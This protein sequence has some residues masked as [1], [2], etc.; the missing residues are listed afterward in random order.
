MSDQVFRWPH[1]AIVADYWR[2]GTGFALSAIFLVLV[3][4]PAI[5]SVFFLALTAIFG[6]YLA[7]TILRS[8]TTL[9]LGPDGLTIS[10][11]LGTDTIR[12]DA[13]DQFALRYYT[14]RRDK[15]AG[16]MD[17]K[18]AG[19]G[20]KVALDDRFDGFRPILERAWEA[21]RTRDLGISSSTYANLT[22]AG[23]LPKSPSRSR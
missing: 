14:L 16:W 6:L 3:P 22:A 4:P 13:L 19:G 9:V 8:R 10:G 12:W 2:S 23:L 20:T 5:A 7:Q 21:A 15:E 17:L 11:I 18:L 1:S